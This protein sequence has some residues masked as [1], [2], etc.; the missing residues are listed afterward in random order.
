MHTEISMRLR[1]FSCGLFFMFQILGTIALYIKGRHHQ[2]QRSAFYFMLYLLLISLFEF[3]V[4]FIHNF[5]G[6]N[7]IPVTDMLQ[8]TVV[9]LALLLLYR[10]THLQSMRPLLAIV[11]FAPYVVGLMAYIVKPMLVIYDSIMLM[12]FLHSIFVISYGFVAVRQFNKQL[13]A[14]FSSDDKLSLRWMRLFWFLYVA[15]AVVWFI[16]TKS[17]SPYGAAVYNVLCSIILGLLCYF[18][19]RQEDM[20]ELLTATSKEETVSAEM[21]AEHA[22]ETTEC[23]E[24]ASNL[25]RY[26]FDEAFEHVFS[27]KRIYLNPQLNIND[28]AQELGT[29]RTYVSNYINQQLNT[30]FYEYVNNWRVKHAMTLLAST[31]L[32][33]Q[34]VANQSGFNSISSFRRYFVSKMG[35]TPSAYKKMLRRK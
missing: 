17:D 2:L 25:P 1:D 31:D 4:F 32:S 18:V 23:I 6:K 27:S 30:T 7:E 29:N 14:N 19:Y 22:V 12:A 21:S 15:L 11:N 28:L 10:L 35:Q 26:H 24:S 33:L 3:Y 5:L 34:E 13:V 8:M 20:L 9:P 16:A